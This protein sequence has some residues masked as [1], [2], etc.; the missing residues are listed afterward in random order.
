MT[1]AAASPHEPAAPSPASRSFV[2]ALLRAL[3]HDPRFRAAVPASNEA[4]AH[5]VE[6]PIDRGLATDKKQHYSQLLVLLS[7]NQLAKLLARTLLLLLLLLA[8]ARF[9]L[10]RR[11]GSVDWVLE[12]RR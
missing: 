1:Q 6:T 10:R 2:L 7:G 5:P 4:A 12:R 9:R 11:R 8:R 3:H